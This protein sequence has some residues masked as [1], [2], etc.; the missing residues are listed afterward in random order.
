MGRVENQANMRLKINNKRRKKMK[1]NKHLEKA[2]NEK[3]KIIKIRRP[4]R[5][6]KQK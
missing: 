2:G 1:M 3:K 5:K 4:L 6:K